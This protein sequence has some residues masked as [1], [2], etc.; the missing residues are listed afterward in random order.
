MHGMVWWMSFAKIFMYVLLQAYCE[1]GMW[2]TI[3]KNEGPVCDTR[4]C[5]EPDGSGRELVP[6]RDGR[7]VE[8]NKYDNVTCNKSE[9]IQFYRKKYYPTCSKPLGIS[10]GSVGNVPP[11]DCPAGYFSTGSYYSKYFLFGLRSSIHYR[12]LPF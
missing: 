12:S 5:D 1:E 6:L 9:V 3:K 2:L 10:T 11:T 8:L 4:I 7:C